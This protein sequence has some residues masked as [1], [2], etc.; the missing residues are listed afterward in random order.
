[1]NKE[2]NKLEKY[3][4]RNFKSWRLKKKQV[5]R[6]ARA[7][8]RLSKKHSCYV[9]HVSYTGPVPLKEQMIFGIRMIFDAARLAKKFHKD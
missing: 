4:R 9:A 1:M 3:S 5:Y 6:L 7:Y 8:D 2:L